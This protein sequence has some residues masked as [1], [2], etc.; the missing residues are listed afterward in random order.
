MTIAPG[1]AE[2]EFTTTAKLQPVGGG[3]AISRTGT[4]LVYASRR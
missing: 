4:A 3:P 1:A 2:D